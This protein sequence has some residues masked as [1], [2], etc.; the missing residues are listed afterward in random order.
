MNS[1]KTEIE[2]ALVDVRKAYRLL[3]DYQRSALD[4]AKYVGSQLG[5]EYQGGY[6]H[7]SNSAPKDGKGFLDNWAWDWLNLIFYEFHFNRQVSR[8]NCLNMSIWLF[9]DTGFFVSDH[10]APDK[11]AV[12]TFASPEKSGTK[13]GFLFYR[14]WKDSYYPMLRDTPEN[15]RRF[16]EKNKL[17]AQ[18][19]DCN[20]FGICCDFSRL[21]DGTSADEVVTEL[22]R[23]GSAKGFPLER[24][25]KA[26]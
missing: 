18:M 5:L 11:L 23:L 6:S 19:E 14:K 16:I 3:Y 4:A 2:T 9:S 20:L 17:P 21:A 22:V 12:S 10:A 26:T 13:L 25:S 7:F 15:L 24:Q 1:T 8:D